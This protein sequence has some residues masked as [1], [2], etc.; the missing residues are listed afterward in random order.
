MWLWEALENKS[1][2]RV[3]LARVGVGV[4]MEK[5]PK[6]QRRKITLSASLYRSLSA[7]WRRLIDWLTVFVW[8]LRDGSMGWV[9]TF[10]VLRLLLS[11]IKYQIT[12]EKFFAPTSPDNDSKIVF[13]SRD[14]VSWQS[15]ILCVEFPRREHCVSL[16]TIRFLLAQQ[17]REVLM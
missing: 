5:E 2:Y 8:K 9:H 17:S 4:R 12:S 1:I 7:D 3:M 14:S 6:G 15:E 11:F 16:I 10:A 13:F